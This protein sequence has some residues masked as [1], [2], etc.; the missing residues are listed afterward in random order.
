MLVNFH[1]VGYIY[2]AL[3]HVEQRRYFPISNSRILISAGE[4]PGMREA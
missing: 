2:Q 1:I 3:F 4:T